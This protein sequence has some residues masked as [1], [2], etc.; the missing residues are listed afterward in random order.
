MLFVRSTSVSEIDTCGPVWAQMAVFVQFPKP[1]RTTPSSTWPNASSPTPDRSTKRLSN[2]FSEEPW[3]ATAAADAEMSRNSLSLPS[4][5]A[6]PKTM[7]P[8]CSGRG[9]CP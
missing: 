6:S 3:Y 8:G 4:T 1:H 2:S 9:I 5:V 7:R